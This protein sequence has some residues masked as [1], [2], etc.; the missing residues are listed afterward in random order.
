M[1]TLGMRRKESRMRDLLVTAIVFGLLPFV[2][3]KPHVGVLLWAWLSM[4]IPHRLTWGFA[5]S[6]P[7][8]QIVAVVTLL[9]L[10][11]RKERTPFPVT[12]LTV[13]YLTFI[14]WMCFTMLF[15]R[16]DMTEVLAAAT[17]AMK[18]HLMI[19]VTMLV[20]NDRQKISQLI[21]V[22]ALSIGYYGIKGGV[23]T[24]LTGGANR[25]WGPPGGVIEGNNELAVA[26]VMIVPLF[27]FLYKVSAGR[28]WHLALIGAMV[29]CAFGI[30][31]THSRGALVAIGAAAV[32]FAWNSGHRVL[33]S[34]MIIGGLIVM[35]NFMPENWSTRMDTITNYEEDGSAQARIRTWTAIWL[36][37]QDHPIVGVGFAFNTSY[38]Y[39]SRTYGDANAHS[40]YFQAMAEHGFVGLALFVALFI[41]AW[42]K[43][44]K[45]AVQ[46]RNMKEMEWVTPLMRMVQ[47]SI[48][49]YMVGGAFLSLL[50]FDLPYYFVAL[51]IIVTQVVKARAPQPQWNARLQRRNAYS[52]NY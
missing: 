28:W 40:I 5:Y 49:G 4:M 33:G 8:A 35:L 24:V 29:A 45:L 17:R 12:G 23:W 9:A 44:G 34:V 13:L 38:E 50:H 11:F 22:M 16:G 7:F 3:R 37:T 42:F 43:A 46:C 18:I 47:V 19:M 39:L 6:F 36:M 32:F 2:L 14:A 21:W 26:L 30:L 25:V 31:G 1:Q 15:A 52:G 41:G 48:V 20:I 51:V 10:P 27:Y